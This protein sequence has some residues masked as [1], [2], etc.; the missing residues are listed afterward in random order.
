MNSKDVKSETDHLLQK[1]LNNH[2]SDNSGVSV[3]SSAIS[4]PFTPP[5]SNPNFPNKIA[6]NLDNGHKPK[7]IAIS[8]IVY[9]DCPGTGTKSKDNEKPS[10]NGD[11]NTP[12]EDC[13]D[14]SGQCATIHDDSKGVYK[15]PG[16]N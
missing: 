14:G 1:L 11:P 9:S 13:F 3:A 6:V 10:S 12:T 4:V 7:T 5:E 15:T 2:S 8:N 16:S